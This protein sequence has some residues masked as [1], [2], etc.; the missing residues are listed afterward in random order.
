MKSLRKRFMDFVDLVSDYFQAKEDLH[1]HVDGC[2]E[3]ASGGLCED[4]AT[5]MGTACGLEDALQEVVAEVKLG[6]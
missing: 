2:C 1:N 5:L 6:L 3:C 4:G